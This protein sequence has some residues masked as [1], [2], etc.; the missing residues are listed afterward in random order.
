VWWAHHAVS[1]EASEER[2]ATLSRFREVAGTVPCEPGDIASQDSV[3]HRV[4]GRAVSVQPS[5]PRLSGAHRALDM[6]RGIPFVVKEKDRTS[7]SCA[8]GGTGTCESG[9]VAEASDVSTW[10][11]PVLGIIAVIQSWA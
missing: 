10:D 6:T 11:D 2:D 7:R 1:L 4:D 3:V 9:W 8:G 5:S